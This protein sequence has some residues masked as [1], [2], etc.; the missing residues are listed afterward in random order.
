LRAL[1]FA[2]LLDR[3]GKFLIE[4]T[5]LSIAPALSYSEAGERHKDQPVVVAASLEEDVKLPSGFFPA[6]AGAD[7]EAQIAAGAG[8]PGARGVFLKDFRPDDLKRTMAAARPDIL[9]LATHA[10][11]NGRSDRSFIVANGGAI[12]INELR[13]LLG[14][15]SGNDLLDLIILSACETAVGDDQASMGLAG[16]AVQAGARSAIASLWQVND[17]GTVELMKNF[18][19]SFRDGQGKAEALR[20]A[21]LALIR[22]GGDF[23]D[24]GIWSAFALLGAWR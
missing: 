19:S 20:N 11:F 17:S 1:P 5:R 2:A 13:G 18:Y 3:G 14:K 21:Q 23:A 16:A 12:P 15:G 24:P 6:L 9:H 22:Q 7:D 4:R 10:A 8:K